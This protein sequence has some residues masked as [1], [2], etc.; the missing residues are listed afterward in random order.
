MYWLSCK[1][2]DFSREEYDI[3][4]K[5]LSPSRKDHIDRFQKEADRARS[6]A[7]EL[8]AQKLL[9]RLGLAGTLHRDEKGRPY[10]TGCDLFV[11]IAHCED[12][13][14][15]AADTKPVGIDI[16]KI[17]PIDVASAA[18]HV[19]APEELDYLQ[20][21]SLTRFYEIWTGK[22][23]WFKKQGTGIQGLKGVNIL[24]LERQVFYGDGFVIQII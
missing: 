19:C 6:L 20:K 4:Y 23:A 1:L 10:L 9:D 21:D 2:T 12:R 15:C 7:G 8:L 16:E 3:A 22:E 24:S 17:R 13:V 5:N 18:R 11:S 14:V